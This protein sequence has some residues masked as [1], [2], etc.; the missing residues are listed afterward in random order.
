MATAD[1][2][3]DSVAV[4][5]PS[6][7]VLLQVP[8]KPKVPPKPVP[9]W[10]GLDP[11]KDKLPVPNPPESKTHVGWKISPLIFDDEGTLSDER[12]G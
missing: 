12:I 9:K 11:V 2:V 6:G 5:L 7:A 10:N 1:A 8:P 4:V 3:V